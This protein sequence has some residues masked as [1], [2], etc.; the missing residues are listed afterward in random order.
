M[1]TRMK[2]ETTKGAGNIFEDIRLARQGRER[3]L[4]RPE[5]KSGKEHGG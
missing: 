2:H 4:D 1:L 5:R 3:R